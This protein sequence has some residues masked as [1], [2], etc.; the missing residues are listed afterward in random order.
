MFNPVEFLKL[1]LV[2]EWFDPG[3]VMADALQ[4]FLNELHVTVVVDWFGQTDVTEM[5][6]AFPRFTTSLAHLVGSRN[7]KTQVVGSYVNLKV[8]FGIGLM[9]LMS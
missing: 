9:P 5:T 2:L 4:D 8:P 3:A 7:T 1:S 6:L